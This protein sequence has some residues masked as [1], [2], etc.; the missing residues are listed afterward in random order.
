MSGAAIAL[1]AAGRLLSD[2]ARWT[3]GAMARNRHG[4]PC[5]PNIVS[6]KCWCPIGAL[7][8]V[9]GCSPA[10]V[11]R[12]R[13]LVTALNCLD[14]AA[15]ELHQHSAEWVNDNLDHAAVMDCMRRAWRRANSIKAAEER[16]AA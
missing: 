8:H 3:Q 2:P 16:E 13:H 14:I 12:R 4:K 10:D 9:C 5:L 6:A 7:H 11:D 15:L 1:E